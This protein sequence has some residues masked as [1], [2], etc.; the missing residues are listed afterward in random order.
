MGYHWKKE[1]QISISKRLSH[2]KQI[3]NISQTVYVAADF[4][5]FNKDVAIQ[6]CPVNEV[7][8]IITDSTLSKDTINHFTDKGVQLKIVNIKYAE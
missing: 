7:D 5:K 2:E 8:M 3:I 6:V 4:S 1:I